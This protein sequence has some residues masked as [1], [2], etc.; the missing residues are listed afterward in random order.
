ML[1]V[2]WFSLRSNRIHYVLLGCS[3]IA[4][5]RLNRITQFINEITLTGCI[6]P[7]TPKLDDQMS[8][9]GNSPER[10]SFSDWMDCAIPLDGAAI[11]TA[12]AAGIISDDEIPQLSPKR[13]DYHCQSPVSVAASDASDV[14]QVKD[15]DK[16]GKKNLQD[17]DN[18]AFEA[19]ETHDSM[20]R[21]H[22]NCD[23]GTPLSARGRLERLGSSESLFRWQIYYYIIIGFNFTYDRLSSQS[24]VFLNLLCC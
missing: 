23:V 5:E 15:I 13:W 2:L 6:P 14:C 11:I 20:E 3:L 4:Q 18:C 16:D 24:Q 8:S 19:P 10:E 22:G 12:A 1:N 21:M 17:H 9:N 7:S